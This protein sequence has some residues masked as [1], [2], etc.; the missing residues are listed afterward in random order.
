MFRKGGSTT[1]KQSR[2]VKRHYYRLAFSD[3]TND[4]ILKAYEREKLSMFRLSQFI[5]HLVIL[6]LE[7]YKAVDAQLETFL[8]AAGC[9]TAP[10]GD[11][12]HGNKNYSVPWNY[13]EPL[14]PQLTFRPFRRRGETVDR[15]LPLLPRRTQNIVGSM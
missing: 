5:R 2:E 14:W 10:E 1:R 7:E 8:Q 3:V 15:E 4:Q 6:G 12:A 11:T 13:I 9:E